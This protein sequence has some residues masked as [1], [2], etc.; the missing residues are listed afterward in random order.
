MRLKGKYQ[1]L[2]TQLL[3]STALTAIENK[4]SNVSNLVI[5]KKKK[6]DYDAEILDT[7]SKYFAT[8]DYNRFTKEKL[9]LKTKKGL[10]NKS[11]TAVFTDNSDLNKKVAAL[12]TKTELKVEKDKITKLEAFDFGYFRG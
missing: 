9:D 5:Q 12:A 8:A 1:V 2:L 7:K 11:D 3:L 6:N 10:V 4:I